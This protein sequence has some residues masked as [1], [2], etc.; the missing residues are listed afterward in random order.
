[1]KPGRKSKAGAVE[2]KPDEDSKAAEVKSGRRTKGVAVE[3]KTSRDSKAVGGSKAK[4]G[5][6][7]KLMAAARKRVSKEPLPPSGPLLV[8]P[9]LAA[10]RDKVGGL[11]AFSYK[12][13]REFFFQCAQV[14]VHY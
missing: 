3:V 7:S 4:T 10:N 2:T 1:M 13:C 12:W 8:S 9:R 14:P 5:G 6:D 11:P